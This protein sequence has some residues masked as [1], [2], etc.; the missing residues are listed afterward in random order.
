MIEIFLED[1]T[2]E[3]SLEC[4]QDFKKQMREGKKTRPRWQKTKTKKNIICKGGD[5]KDYDLLN[6]CKLCRVFEV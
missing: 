1:V 4:M 2:F 5:G 3:S 6:N